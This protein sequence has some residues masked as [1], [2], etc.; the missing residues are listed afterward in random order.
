ML[1]TG[2]WQQKPPPKAYKVLQPDRKRLKLKHGVRRYQ[3]KLKKNTSAAILSSTKIRNKYEQKQLSRNLVNSPVKMSGSSANNDKKL[4][5]A[6]VRLRKQKMLESLRHIGRV[7][8]SNDLHSGD[9]SGLGSSSQSQMWKELKEGMRRK[10]GE[11]AY[12]INNIVIP[13]SIAAATR[14]ERLQYKEI[15]TPKWREVNSSAANDESSV[16]NVQPEAPEVFVSLPEPSSD[17]HVDLTKLSTSVT[18]L[19]DSEVEDLSD[20]VFRQRHLRCEISEKQR[21]ATALPSKTK[22]RSRTSQRLDS[23]TACS[24]QI[25]P[26]SPDNVQSQES[27]Y[28]VTPPSTPGLS[29]TAPE[30][31]DD[32]MRKA[33]HQDHSR[34][35][36]SSVSSAK[37]HRSRSTSHSEERRLFYED[38]RPIV[39]SWTKRKF[40]LMTEEYEMLTASPSSK[41]NCLQLR[42]GISSAK[43]I[44]EE[45]V[46]T[47]PNIPTSPIHAD[48]S[49]TSSDIVEDPDDPEWTV[50]TERHHQQPIRQ[51]PLVLK[52]AKR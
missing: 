35:R 20:D 37:S 46:M 5:R 36:S 10:R 14:V 39:P 34:R 7:G 33:A 51:S 29:S 23:V 27:A 9:S 19:D 17:P 31:G 12:D 48:N 25:D 43:V 8:S 13:Y 45:M 24:T 15:L 32:L 49:D 47:V 52:L 50:V 26:S 6:E 40:P 18:E 22:R 38:D 11:S 2:E 41:N 1:K 30:D 16:V 3:R 28:T 4:M 21:F 44:T 42:Y